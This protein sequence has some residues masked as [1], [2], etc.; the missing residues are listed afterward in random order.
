MAVAIKL[1]KIGRKGE[2]KYRVVV[3]EKRSRRDT[4][5]VETLGWLIKTVKGPKI[6][7]DKER[8]KYWRGQGAQ[9]TPTVYKLLK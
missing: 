1:T 3:A 5:P 7:V 6:E 9:P 4:K 8:Y 2:A